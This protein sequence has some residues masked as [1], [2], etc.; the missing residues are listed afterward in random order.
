MKQDIKKLEELEKKVAELEARLHHV[1][2]DTESEAQAESSD[3]E[4]KGGAA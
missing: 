3:N 1:A 2:S 4:S